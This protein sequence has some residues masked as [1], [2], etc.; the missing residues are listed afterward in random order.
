MQN[1]FQKMDAYDINQKL[2]NETTL[3][4]GFLVRCY[5][6]ID[7]F[8]VSTY[9]TLFNACVF[10]PWIV[11]VIVK[12]FGK[13]AFYVAAIADAFRIANGFLPVNVEFPLPV[14]TKL[15][16]PDDLSLSLIIFFERAPSCYF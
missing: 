8:N 12:L 10:I 5:L 16:V 9:L 7:S 1:L 3:T 4:N 14:P 13:T 2:C 15:F 11:Y 6:E